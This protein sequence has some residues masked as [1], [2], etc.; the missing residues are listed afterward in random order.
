MSTARSPRKNRSLRALGLNPRAQG[1]NPRAL[2]TNPK[3]LRALR[4]L[5]ADR[6]LLDFELD[7]LDGLTGKKEEEKNE[8]PH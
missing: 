4:A 8:E 2:G 1:T 3:A 5:E 7:E 6:P